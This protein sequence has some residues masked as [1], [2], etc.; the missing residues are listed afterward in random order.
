M[1]TEL[2]PTE[3]QVV[4]NQLYVRSP[5]VRPGSMVAVVADWCG[6]CVALKKSVALARQLYPFLAFFVDSEKAGAAKL[7]ELGVDGFP[8]VFRVMSDGRL[9]R[10]EGSRAPPILASYF[11]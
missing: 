9:Q 3:L 1:T 7:R 10:Y 8:T 4:G 6:H 11:R 5:L 2:S